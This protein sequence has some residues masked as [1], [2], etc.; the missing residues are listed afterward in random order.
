MYPKKILTSLIFCFA[1]VF[2]ASGQTLEEAQKHFYYKNYNRAAAVLKNI[3]QQEPGN[4]DAWY[5]L[6]EVYLR[7]EKETEAANTIAAGMQIFRQ[8]ELQE[9]KFPLILIGAAHLKLNSGD[10]VGSRMEMDRILQLGKYKDTDALLAV[11]RANIESQHGDPSWAVE[12]LRIAAKRDKRNP[13]IYV[14]MGD[15]Y[16]K[17]T[18]GGNAVLSYNEALSIDKT[19]A[20]AAYRDGRIY[21]S[22]NNP[23]VY[24]DRFKK[25]LLIDS[26]YSPAMLELYYYYVERD[27][28]KA[29]EMLD[30]YRRHAEPSI[31]MDYLQTD[32]Y[33]LS[34]KYKEAISAAKQI[35][36]AGPDS[37]HA[38]LQKLM[39]Y[40]YAALK[41][42]ATALIHLEK[43]FKNQ[44]ADKLVAKDFLLKASLLEDLDNDRSSAIE[45]YR[46]AIAA[47][48]DQ[49]EKVN[50]MISLANLQKELGNE[51]REAVWRERIFITKESPTNLDLYNWG[52]ALYSSKSYSR[53]DSVFTLYEVK[54]PEQIYGSLMR[55]RANARI[56]TS[57][58]LGLA[59]P[60]YL[61][62]ISIAAK[63]SLKNKSLLL[64][65]YAYLG[66]YEANI[67][68]NYEQAL[69]YFNSMLLYEPQNEDAL[70]YTAILRRILEKQEVTN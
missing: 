70:K 50:Y 58:E 35:M 42:S 36:H 49:K 10:S 20:E 69:N 30:A 17:M 3:V 63:D 40:S 13:G 67:R 4:T 45:W 27:V 9:K 7:Q 56:D 38:R 8:H 31:Y 11:A 21:Q 55:A 44:P 15:A 41:D 25:A 47:E 53:A 32:L 2:I 51:E 26:N 66:T 24:V 5:W 37:T 62:L 16:R 33:Y 46:K 61:R 65:A 57:M 54:Y 68:K 19:Y 59:V 23:E 14:M 52:L 39:A 48:T 18:D 34:R 64:T 60:H 1:L 29:Q 12:L 22:Q 6:S 28:V 43:Y